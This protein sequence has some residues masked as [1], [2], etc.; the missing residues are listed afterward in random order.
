MKNQN[1][2]NR[3]FLSYIDDEFKNMSYIIFGNLIVSILSKLLCQ[4]Q[5]FFF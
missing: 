3:Y 1:S 4:A 2:F 5:Y